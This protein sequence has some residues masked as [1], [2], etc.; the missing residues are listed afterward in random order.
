MINYQRSNRLFENDYMV[1]ELAKIKKQL[2]LEYLENLIQELYQVPYNEETF[3]SYEAFFSDYINNELPN[4]KRAI[5]DCIMECYIVEK[6][7]EIGKLSEKGILSN[8]RRIIQE[9]ENSLVEYGPFHLIQMFEKKEKQYEMIQLFV[10]YEYRNDYDYKNILSED[11]KK[12]VEFYYATKQ[13][14]KEIHEKYNYIIKKINFLLENNIIWDFLNYIESKE[15]HFLI[16][17][18]KEYFKL[19]FHDI[20]I[21]FSVIEKLTSKMNLVE[22]IQLMNELENYNAQILIKK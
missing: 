18:I 15:Y 1:N 3:V 5:K 20:N 17:E 7:I 2:N 13:Y 9:I 12:R 16:N 4:H 11:E 14:Q 21:S 10:D 6:L 19:G 8:D 22:I